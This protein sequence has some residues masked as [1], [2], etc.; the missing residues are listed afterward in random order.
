[1]A[2]SKKSFIAYSDW[3]NIF[4][5]LPD[6]DAGKLIKHIFAYV[7][8]ENPISDS[9]LIKAV[10]ANIKTTLKR[11]LEKWETQL[12][13]RKDAG[14]RSAE[15]REAK[16]NDRSTVVDESVRNSTDSVSD[17]VNVSVIDKNINIF[18]YKKCSET[19]FK[20]EVYKF[21]SSYPQ[22]MLN[23]FI[24]YWFEKNNKGVPKVALQK[25]FEINRRL[26][27]W[28]S[29]NFNSISSTQPKK[30]MYYHITCRDGVGFPFK[31]DPIPESKYEEYKTK[32]YQR[33]D[34]AVIES[35]E[36]KSQSWR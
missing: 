5:E 13:Q 10:F 31:P 30:E 25:T 15:L 22:K 19:E 2:E 7:N 8:D 34:K 21:E 14:K 29:N 6:E 23:D 3:K 35:E 27:K 1:M 12:Q 24:D 28:S 9:I 16:V 20:N 36:L 18:N 11:D 26:A 32:F 33:A 17:N 4:D